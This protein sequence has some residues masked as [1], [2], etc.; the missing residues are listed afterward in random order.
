MDPTTGLDTTAEARPRRIALP[1][2]RRAG[3]RPAGR[4]PQSTSSTRTRPPAPARRTTRWWRPVGRPSP[5]APARSSSRCCASSATGATTDRMLSGR[6][7]LA[8]LPALQ[9][10]REQLA[11]L[12]GRG[13]L[14]EAGADAAAPL[15]DVPPGGPAPPRAARRPGRPRTAADGPAHAGAGGRASTRSRRS[16]RAGR[17]ARRCAARAGCSRSTGCPCSPSSSAPTAP[18][19][20]QRIRKP[21]VLTGLPAA[22]RTT[23]VER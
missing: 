23:T 22:G 15:P 14:G 13:F 4:D 1:E 18:V 6:A 10:M 8:T 16:P 21:L 19:S 2:R 20:D 12:V 9:D 17:R 5:S 7:E 3:R 11:R